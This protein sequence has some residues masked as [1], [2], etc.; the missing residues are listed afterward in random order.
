MLTVP[1]VVLEAVQ[2]CLDMYS[3]TGPRETPRLVLDK[4]HKRILH[5]DIGYLNKLDKM[6]F[7]SSKYIPHWQ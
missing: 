4:G 3:K 5:I 2:N 6:Y 1:Q 7:K